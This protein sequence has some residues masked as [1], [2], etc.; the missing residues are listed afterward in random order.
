MK[1]KTRDK[2][3]EIVMEM[4][5]GF[6][7]SALYSK[8]DNPIG[9][10]QIIHGMCEH[11]KRYIE[12]IN[13]LNEAK[14][15][16]LI[17]DLRGHGKSIDEIHVLGNVGDYNR[18]VKDQYEITNFLKNDNPSLPINIL[19]HSMGTLIARMYL[20]EYDNEINKLILSGTVAYN[21]GVWLAVFLA[22]IFNKNKSSKL[23]FAFSNGFSFK[24]DNSWLSYNLENIEK[25]ESDPLCGFK[26]TNLVYK[27]LYSMVNNLHKYNKFKFQNP[28]LDIYMLSG[29]DDRVTGGT[30]G[31]SKTKKTLEKIGYHNIKIKEYERMK[32]EILNED[33]KIEVIDDIIK[34]LGER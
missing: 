4:N 10:V 8:V 9:V 23:L 1:W 3:N 16:V 21:T 34:F 2:M 17:S 13:K 25:Y 14:Y 11:K 24:E 18:L 29:C 22:S 20:K 27:A 33:S 32:H 6:K 30:K 31:L 19:A 12:I 28:N 7:I 26:F 5:D 15:N